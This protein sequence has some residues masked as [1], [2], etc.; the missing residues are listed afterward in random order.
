ML[1]TLRTLALAL[2]MLLPVALVMLLPVALVMLL[3]VALV[4]LLPVA[5]VMLLPV[6]TQV[7]P[8]VLTISKRLLLVDRYQRLVAALL[9]GSSWASMLLLLPVVQAARTPR[10]WPSSRSCAR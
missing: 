5:L 6:A 4:M 1:L 9:G 2:V 10:L 8:S 7:L 3:P